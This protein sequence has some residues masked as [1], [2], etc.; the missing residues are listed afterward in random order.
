MNAVD[1]NR[2]QVV[3]AQLDMQKNT[4][5]KGFRERL[6]P[7]FSSSKRVGNMVRR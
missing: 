6:M 2:R 5:Q 3:E 7:C 4:P 1:A